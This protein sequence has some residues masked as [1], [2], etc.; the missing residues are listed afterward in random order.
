MGIIEIGLHLE[1]IWDG[2]EDFGRVV[3]FAVWQH[4]GKEPCQIKIR[5]TTANLGAKISAILII[6]KGNKPFG[7]TP[8]DW[9]RCNKI[10][11][12]SEDRKTKEFRIDSGWQPLGIFKI[13]SFCFELNDDDSRSA[14]SCAK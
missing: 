10:Y 12:N 14:F 11:F 6:T 5:I 2:E 3:T 9:S 1:E 8:P 13:L 7:Y 4:T